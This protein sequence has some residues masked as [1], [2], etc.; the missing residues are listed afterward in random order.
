DGKVLQLEH[1]FI[2]GSFVRF[3]IIPDMLR[4]APMFKRL[5]A[6]LKGKGS[7][8][9][10]VGR[11]RA[12]AMQLTLGLQQGAFPFSP[13]DALISLRSQPTPCVCAHQGKGSSNLGVGRGRAMAMRAKARARGRP[14][15]E[16][17][18]AEPWPCEPKLGLQ[19]GE[20]W[21]QHQMGVRL[22]AAA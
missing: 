2:R 16:W 21:E 22:W 13:K 3:V 11:G 15:W 19:Q 18:G 8:N 4:N 17:A 9:L 12:M 7:S 5:E 1:V 14:T 20:H 10:G 6:K